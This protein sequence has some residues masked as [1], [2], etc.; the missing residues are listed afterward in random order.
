MDL[1]AHARAVL[2]GPDL[3]AR[4]VAGLGSDPQRTWLLR[5]PKH[6]R[7]DFL[8]TVVDGGA[9]EQRWMLL[10]DDATRHTYVAEVLERE[11]EPD[12]QAIWLLGQA[13]NVR[14]SYIAEVLDAR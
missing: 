12:R 4:R 10:Q 5:R 13:R 2:T 11:D 3:I 8:Q 6:V 1:P 7:R 14:E 9:D